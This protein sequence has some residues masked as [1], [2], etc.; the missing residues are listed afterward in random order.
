MSVLPNWEVIIPEHHSVCPPSPKKKKNE[1]SES[2]PAAAAANCCDRKERAYRILL[3]GQ[4]AVECNT[5]VITL[6][7]VGWK[8]TKPEFLGW[9][10]RLQ[11]CMPLP[12][13]HSPALHTVP[14]ALLQAILRLSQEKVP[15][16]CRVQTHQPH[17]YTHSKCLD[18]KFQILE[19]F[20][21]LGGKSKKEG[22]RLPGVQKRVVRIESQNI[23]KLN[24]CKE[25][26]FAKD[27][28]HK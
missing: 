7:K 16:H 9:R 13:A 23:P 6:K 3:G 14:W 17:S 27:K 26:L 10:H 4:A 28:G 15:E 12:Q 18:S 8:W 21:S 22:C 25:E 24:S 11:S 20:I 19:P 1:H 5:V 2:C